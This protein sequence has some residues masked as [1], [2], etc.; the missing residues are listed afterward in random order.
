MF[1]IAARARARGRLRRDRRRRHRLQGDR[2]ARRTVGDQRRPATAR[3]RARPGSRPC[4]S[5][6]CFAGRVFGPGFGFALGC[7]SLFA[8]A[9]I[10]GGVGPW[11]PYQMFGCAWIGLFAGLLPPLPRQGGD[12]DARRLRRVRRLLLRVHAQPAVLAV[13]RRPGQ[14]DRLPARARRSPTSGTATSCSTRPPRSAGTPAAPSPTSS[15]SC[16]SV[17]PRSRRSAG[18][19]DAP[20]SKLRCDSTLL[21]ISRARR[22]LPPRHAT[23]CPGCRLR[24]CG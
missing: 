10:T 23:R 2:D 22:P 3:A 6:W 12:R 8:S 9:I 16:C 24:P 15:A 11:M 1:G 14:L 17:P 7:T 19:L 20:T 18:P 13:L 5:C 21:T 4:S